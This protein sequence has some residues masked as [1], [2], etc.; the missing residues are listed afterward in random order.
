M[1]QWTSI[2][3]GHD[4]NQEAVCHGGSNFCYLYTSLNE[5]GCWCTNNI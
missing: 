2:V 5:A 3:C 1:N 4:E